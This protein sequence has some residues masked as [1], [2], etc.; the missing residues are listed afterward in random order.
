[1][2]T[3]PSI[4]IPSINMNLQNVKE[5]F[6]KFENIKFDNIQMPNLNI[7][8]FNIDTLNQ[9]IN[10]S[11]QP[12]KITYAKTIQLIKNQTCTI[13]LPS[14]LSPNIKY[15]NYLQSIDNNFFTNCNFINKPLI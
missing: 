7:N 1:M 12:F 2:P 13:Y 4:A 8:N 6:Q 15:I 10:T 5:N 9:N 3:M 11:I 14:L